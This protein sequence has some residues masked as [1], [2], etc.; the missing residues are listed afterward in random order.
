MPGLLSH[1]LIAVEGF[2]SGLAGRWAELSALASEH[3]G[4]IGPWVMWGLVAFFLLFFISKATKLAFDLLRLVILPSAV[5]TIA[6]GLLYPCWPP[7]KTFPA[8]LAVT[9]AMMF[10]RGR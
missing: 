9:T 1:I 5:L 7:M 6:V 4:P 10:F 8:L 3:L 2:L